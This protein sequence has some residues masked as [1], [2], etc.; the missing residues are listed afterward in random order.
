MK[1]SILLLGSIF[2]SL[3][4]YAQVGINTVSPNARLDIRS[5][6]Q[7]TPSSTD[8]VLIPIIDEFPLTTPGASQ[9]GMLVFVSGSGTPERG[10]YY[11][12]NGGSAWVQFTPKSDIWD[13]NGN[14]GTDGGTNNFIGTNDNQPLMFRTNNTNR[15]RLTTTGVLETINASQSV[16][17]GENSSPVSTGT[18][19]INIGYNTANDLTTG[20]LNTIIGHEAGILLTTQSNNT[21]LGS[22]TGYSATTGTNNTLL[23][24]GAGAALS[25]GSSNTL[26]GLSAGQRNNTGGNNTMLGRTAGLYNYAGV[27]NVYLGMEAGYS[28]LDA[29][30]TAA[31]SNNTLV[32]YRAGRNIQ[33]NNNVFLGYY[34]GQSETGSDRLYIENSNSTTPLIGGDFANNRVGV[35]RP[36]GSLSNT[37]EVG[38]T[39]S[40]AAA[41]AWVANSDRRLKSNINDIDG[42]VALTLIE[43]MRGVTFEWNDEK[44]GLERPEGVQIGFI[45]QELMEVFP[46]KVTKDNLGFYQTAY[47]DYDPLFVEAI[48]ALLEKLES[49]QDE[50]AIM[51]ERIQQLEVLVKSDSEIV[52]AN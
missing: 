1:K 51:K 41:G 16:F 4:S 22:Y 10:L 25:T 9:D 20:Q 14:S 39:A 42:K 5:T 28:V 46:E 43:Q 32:G 29:T 2:L 47:G 12:N 24:S 21:F 30:E 6:N 33:G 50:I 13:I 11:W 3:F 18:G 52:Q 45:A 7:A 19:N 23:G 38:G 27:N 26:V 49:Q 44:T 36:I 37:F 34:A 31:Y 35:N 40:K 48:K 17:I 15:L 8:G